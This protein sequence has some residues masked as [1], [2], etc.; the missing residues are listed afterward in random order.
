MNKDREIRRKKE[1]KNQIEKEEWK[2]KKKRNEKRKE[3]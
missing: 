1:K 2:I 3:R